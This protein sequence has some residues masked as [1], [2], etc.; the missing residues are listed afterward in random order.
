MNTESATILWR[1][2]DLPGFDS[3]RLTGSERAAGRGNAGSQGWL[4]EG[5]ALFAYQGLPCRLEY[6]IG[7]TPGWLTRW[8]QV[9]G[10]LG[11]TAVEI[12]V[13]ADGTG[14]WALNG[15]P[16]PETAGCLDLDLNFSPVTNLLPI[17]RL[18][19]AV[20]EAA[21]VR[22]AWLTFPGFTLEPLEQV[23][24]RTGESAYRY[25]SNGGAFV[26]DLEVNAAGFV[27]RYPGFWEQVQ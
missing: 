13:E 27:T 19:L 21:E 6:R 8:G 3:A 9:S 25:E 5:T 4:L 18:E 7:C 26:R 10:W 15:R 17:R 22:A 23:Y 11:D 2:L 12:T 1:R 24:R 14:G 20:G 16:V